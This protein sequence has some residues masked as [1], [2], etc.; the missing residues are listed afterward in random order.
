[1]EEC[2]GT[3]IEGQRIRLI[4]V[5]NCAAN[6]NSNE[7]YVWYKNRLKL[8]DSHANSPFLSLDPIS[9]VDTG[10][11]VCAMIDYEDLPLSAVSLTVLRTHRNTRVSN[12]I[13]DVG[14]KK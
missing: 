4:C 6:L 10:S 9:Y 2:D 12:E 3:V 13:P 1:M 14:S 8:N 11:Y 5:P 7:G